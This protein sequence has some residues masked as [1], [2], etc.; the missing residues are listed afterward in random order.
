M[1]DDI[2]IWKKG[3]I[4]KHLNL[5]SKTEQAWATLVQSVDNN[6]LQTTLP[7]DLQEVKDCINWLLT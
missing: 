2:W 7:Q 4:E 3:T 5:A 6:G 1:N